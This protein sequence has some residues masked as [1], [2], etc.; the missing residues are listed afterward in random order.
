MKNFVKLIMTVCLLLM[1]SMPAFAAEPTTGDWGE[2]TWSYDA[3]TATL[4]ISGQGE[5]ASLEYG[6]AYPWWGFSEDALHLVVEDGVATL[7][8]G[9]F[10]GFNVLQSAQIAGTVVEIGANAFSSCRDLTDV[11]LEEGL[12]VLGDRAFD[13]CFS[14]AEIKLPDSLKII[15][16]NAFASSGLITVEIPSGVEMIGDYVFFLADNFRAIHVHEDNAYYT[17]NDNGALF[18][19]DQTKL[20]ILP[21][22]YEGELYLPAATEQIPLGDLQD[23]TKLTAVHVDEESAFF[24]SDGQGVLYQKDGNVLLF[25][26]LSLSGTYEVHEG[27]LEIW[28]E[29]FYECTLLEGVILPNGLK[30]IGSSAFYGCAELERV[31]IPDTVRSIAMYAFSNCE[32]LRYVFL[33]KSVKVVYEGAFRYSEAVTDVFY[34]GSEEEWAA[35]EIESEN[36]WL[37][38]A[39]LH[40][41]ANGIEEMV[42]T[43]MPTPMPIPRPMDGV[44]GAYG[45]RT[46]TVDDSFY[47]DELFIGRNDDAQ[48]YSRVASPVGSVLAYENGKYMRVQEIYDQIAIEWYDNQ[49]KLLDQT[50]IPLEL[51]VY[52]GIYIGEDYNFVVCGE[53][54]LLERDDQEVVRVIR[55]SKDWERQASVSLYGANTYIPFD[56]GSLR[57]ASAGDMLYIHTAHEMY[58]AADG[59]NHQ[60]NMNFAVRISDM[61]ITEEHYKGGD[62]GY[63]S[64]SFNQYILVDGK[65]VVTVDHGDGFPRALKLSRYQGVAGE[66]RYTI[67]DEYGNNANLKWLEIFDIAENIGHY[68][69]TGVQVGGFE[70]SSTHYL[71][72]GASCP[73]T[74]GIDQQA[75]QQNIFITAVDKQAFSEVKIKTTY[76]TDYSLEDEVRVS[77]PHL[78]KVDDDRFCLLWTADEMLYYCMLDGAGQRITDVFCA[79][80]KLSDCKPIVVGGCVEWYVCSW[81]YDVLDL[82]TKIYRIPLSTEAGH[83]IVVTSAVAPTCTKEG[84]TEGEHCAD[85][86]EVIT[87]VDPIPPLGHRFAN[88]VCSLCGVFEGMENPFTDVSATDWFF[89]PVMWA[90][91][92]GVTG[93]KTATTFAPNDPCTR[94]QVVTFLWAANGKPEPK[95]MNNPFDDVDSGAWYCK[96]V[97]WA[98]E[99]SI[100]GGTSPT[101]FSPDAPCTRAQVVTFLYAAQG[102]PAVIG[103]NSFA[104]VSENAWYLLPVQWAAENDVTGGIGGGL[105]GPDQPCTRSQVVTFLYKQK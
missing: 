51:P 66:E 71:V 97:M 100:T 30:Y 44:T 21:V 5:M 80:G 73:Q 6:E 34:G 15:G 61:T 86:G 64:H 14:L 88:G 35:V 84:Y 96:A 74:G 17:S 12:V 102:K 10:D 62:F 13:L 98:V 89:K 28:S 72:A 59:I 82:D 37:K 11:R 76:F 32:K 57:F 4:T 22:Q 45:L 55:Y 40:F 27:T 99:N 60:A 38:Y 19:K 104:D 101:T 48:S 25:A 65:D 67:K 75:A 103:D 2:V 105:F 81:P 79:E 92:T 54:N 87:A 1:L 83:R 52:G 41:H 36:D 91:G 70:A 47:F 24:H 7:P 23:A 69:Y 31:E 43:P 63:C 85:C 78:V 53:K 49:Y 58:T 95:S 68:N 29:A 46:I 56:A 90:V 20:V 26:P 50:S 94:A 8:E 16:D 42:P 93:G 9:A 18:T 33:P 39:N 3:E 77:A